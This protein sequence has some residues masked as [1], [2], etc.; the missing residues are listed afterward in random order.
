MRIA[1][2]L[3]LG[4][5]GCF[6]T[7][8]SESIERRLSGLGVVSFELGYDGLHGVGNGMDTFLDV[9]G[10]ATTARIDKDSIGAGYV[11]VG[12]TYLF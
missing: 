7:Q 9:A 8:A 5:V 6:S 1:A 10:T 3:A 11:S 12:Y 2:K 4:G